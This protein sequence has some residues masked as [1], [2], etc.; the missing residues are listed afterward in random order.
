M[1]S[2]TLLLLL[3]LAGCASG[4]DLDPSL[5]RGEQAYQSFAVEA[6]Q[7]SN[8][9]YRVGPLDVLDVTVFR[10]DNLSAKAVTVDAGGRIALPLIG[11]V[12]AAGKSSAQI[13]T[14]IETRLR[15]GYLRNPQ[16]S[17]V[18]ST[19]VAQKV[20][21]QGQVIE[22]GIYPL[23]GPT[24]LMGAV[25][26]AKGETKT[27]ALREVAVFRNAGGRRM[28]A[29]FD[30]ESIRRGAS[31]DPQIISNDII[32]VGYSRS[33]GFWQDIISSVPLVSVFRVL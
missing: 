6:A 10:E 31:P 17:V 14:E 2:L 21:V 5:A 13:A 1:R 29:V 8:A 18:V 25:A 7:Q 12:E 33:K 30:L 20:V 24:T 4:P 26:L 19:P 9:D 32:V 11:S 15:N 22:P 3:A 27:A 28:G 23:T 16:V